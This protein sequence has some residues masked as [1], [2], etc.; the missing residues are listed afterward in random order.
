MAEEPRP[1]LGEILVKSGAISLRDLEG[2]LA[3]QEELKTERGYQTK[4]GTLLLEHGLVTEETLAMAFAFQQEIE[5]QDLREFNPDLNL[6]EKIPFSILSRFK[7]VPLYMDSSRLVIAIHDPVDSF[8]FDLLYKALGVHIETRSGTRS[9]IDAAHKLCIQTVQDSGRINTEFDVDFEEYRLIL[10]QEKKKTSRKAGESDD[11]DEL[12]SEL[13]KLAVDD[14]LR[15][16]F[17]VEQLRALHFSPHLEGVIVYACNNHK[18]S[19][20]GTMSLENYES[21]WVSARSFTEYKEH[22]PAFAA[23]GFMEVPFGEDDFM[24]FTATFLPGLGGKNLLIES[25]PQD[26]RAQTWEDLGFL[27]SEAQKLNQMNL[28]EKGILIFGG[29]S[30]GKSTL[31]AALLN[32]P[33][34]RDSRIVSVSD[35]KP[36]FTNHVIPLPLDANREQ[37][38]SLGFFSQTNLEVVG[39]DGLHPTEIANCLRVLNY[40]TSVLSAVSNSPLFP[41]LASIEKQ[42]DSLGFVLSNFHA[43]IFVKLVPSLCPYC[44]QPHRPTPDEIASMGLKPETL[45]KPFFYFAGGCDYCEHQG[46]TEF[47]PVYEFLHITPQ[48]LKIMQENPLGGEMA[49]HIMK[50]GNLVSLNNVAKEKLYKGQISLQTYAHILQKK[51]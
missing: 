26:Q 23:Q 22:E 9:G 32:S 30:M 13:N 24:N 50:A 47:T 20:Y 29:E 51:I 8:L 37:L 28:R 33:A 10:Q 12:V 18:W 38:Q 42:G 43:A 41:T 11:A 40:R 6:L 1:K 5:F 19:H 25:F 46:Y 44:A 34:Y 17:R 14:I 16:A 48:V 35:G 45:K 3:Q 49:M 7:F 2:F 27:S 39:I 36:D 15:K 4:L 21:L 31:Y